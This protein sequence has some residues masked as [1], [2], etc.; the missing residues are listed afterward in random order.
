VQGAIELRIFQIQ[1]L[2]SNA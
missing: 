1:V 2:R